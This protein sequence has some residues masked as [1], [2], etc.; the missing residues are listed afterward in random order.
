M[1]PCCWYH[2]RTVKY[3]PFTGSKEVNRND[4]WENPD[5]GLIKHRLYKVTV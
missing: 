1:S 2:S 4:L 5:A 3:G